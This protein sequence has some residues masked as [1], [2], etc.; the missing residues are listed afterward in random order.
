[1]ILY[2]LGMQR[3]S[4]HGFNFDP[5]LK[6]NLISKIILNP[7]TCNIIILLMVTN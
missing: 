4:D 6:F 2:D 1:M 3:S 7:D 5:F